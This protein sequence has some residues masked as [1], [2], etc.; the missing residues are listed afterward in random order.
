MGA[1]GREEAQLKLSQLQEKLDKEVSQYTA[2]LQ[3]VQRQ[4]CHYEQ[5]HQFLV[6]KNQE[7]FVDPEVQEARRRRERETAEG[8]RK[9]SH[10]KAILKYQ[11]V[12]DRLTELTG[13][14]NP[15]DIFRKYLENEEKNFAEFNFINEQNSEM[16]TLKEEIQEA[17][18]ALEKLSLVQKEE[19][20]GLKNQE[21]Q[22]MEEMKV[23]LSNEAIEV[24]SKYQSLNNILGQLKSAIQSLFYKAKCD[25]TKLKELLGASHMGD[26]IVQLLLSLIEQR[27]M[28]LLAAQAFHEFSESSTYNAQATALRLLGQSEEMPPKKQVLP[29]PPTNVE[30]PLGLEQI[31]DRPLTLE[32]IK[33]QIMKS[34]RNKEQ[35]KRGSEKIG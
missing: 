14:S 6:A 7:R 23:S 24:D 13:F 28:D 3:V 16:E 18:E 27:V 5:L 30:D 4:M 2:E 21:L 25:D 15:E 1:L 35:S 29:Q 17:Q 9:T 12:L 26:K 20:T 10:E 34:I 31:D 11:E 8:L 32:E 19:E 33:A 22:A